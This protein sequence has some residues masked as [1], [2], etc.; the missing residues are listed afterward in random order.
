MK[1]ARCF[2]GFGRSRGGL[3]LRVGR[4]PYHERAVRTSS[5]SLLRHMSAFICAVSTHKRNPVAFA[6]LEQ[7]P[8]VG[9]E[10]PS[11][12]LRE[13]ARLAT[14]DPL[15]DLRAR[16]ARDEQMAGHTI[17][18]AEG[19]RPVA[20]ALHDVGLSSVPVEV[21]AGGAS[22]DGDTLRV[23]EQALAD[24]FAIVFRQSGFEAMAESELASDAIRALY[25]AMSE[26]GGAEDGPDDYDELLDVEG[27]GQPG[28]ATVAQSGSAEGTSTA[29][30]GGDA[31]DRDMRPMAEGDVAT[32]SRAVAAAGATAEV[33]LGESRDVAVALGL[34]VWYG[35][36]AADEFPV[37]DQAG[38][39]QRARTVRRARQRGARRS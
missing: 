1:A 19:G 4:H 13:I 36:R 2:A 16:L 15:A 5:R 10:K 24:T 32:A 7:F 8:G 28:A 20:K 22:R 34:A 27:D 39:T 37:T 12:A 11:Y 9:D 3:E 14:E 33:D 38:A 35:E 18:L 17:V 31:H 6:L 25:V 21:G 26:D 23:T 29:R 30:V